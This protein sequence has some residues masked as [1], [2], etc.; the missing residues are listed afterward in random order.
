MA[1]IKLGDE[2][3]DTVS[4][5]QGIA[6]ARHSYLQGCDRVGVQPSINSDGGLPRIETFDEPSL[7]II[8]KQKAKEGN[9]TRGGPE[10]YMPADRR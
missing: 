5:F 4:G 3:K 1:N 2:V 6:I 10:K 9:R 8:T 7:I